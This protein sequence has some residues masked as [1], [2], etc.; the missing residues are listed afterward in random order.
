MSAMPDHLEMT[1]LLALRDGEGTVGALSHVETCEVCRAE[2][3]RLYRTRAQLRA[4]ATLQP[5]R[6][7]WPGVVS[8]VRSYRTRRR[9]TLGA[10]GLAAAAALA[11]V[12]A[13]RGPA[14]PQAPRIAEDPWV[15][16][17][18]SPDLGAMI[19]RSRELELLLQ[20]HVNAYRV[21]NAPTALA[22]SVLEDRITLIDAAL[23][24]SRLL[25]ID[26]EVMHG[27][28]QE[29]VNA[30]ESLVGLHLAGRESEWRY[31]Q[32]SEWR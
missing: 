4:L 8:R 3:D 24:D 18:S 17:M 23:S 6:D 20:N 22:V 11:G 28:W 26:R 25:G 12:I 1:E 32:E 13:L 30:L 7:L 19:V 5:H 15:A 21:F 29:R 9:L 16:E 10:I 14:A 27:L 2:L 31:S